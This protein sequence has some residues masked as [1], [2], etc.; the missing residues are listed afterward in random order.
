MKFVTGTVLLAAAILP[1]S[2]DSYALPKV[3]G[4]AKCSCTCASDNGTNEHSEISIAAPN[5]DTATCGAMN[6]TDCS[7]VSGQS[8][9]TLKSCG[10]Y[11]SPTPHMNPMAPK[12][13]WPIVKK[14]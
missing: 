3:S 5:G 6:G 1:I 14:P 7:A 4:Y 13:K 11:I 2:F 9:S 10:G 8:G 12:V